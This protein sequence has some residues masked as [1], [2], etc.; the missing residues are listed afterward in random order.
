MIIRL[1]MAASLAVTLITSTAVGETFTDEERYARFMLFAE[2]KPM[3]LVVAGISKDAAKIDLTKESIQAAAE[4]RLRSA[5]LYSTEADQYLFINTNVYLGA[6]TVRVQYHKRLF[7]PLSGEQTAAV[8]WESAGIGQHAGDSVYILSSVSRHL[9]KFL[10][11]FLRVNEEA[12][13]KR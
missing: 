12:C 1:I 13:G 11:E 2:C 6:F 10:V 7:D 8:S 4:S 3:Q 5:R 9:D